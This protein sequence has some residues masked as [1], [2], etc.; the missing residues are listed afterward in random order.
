MIPGIA[1][2]ISMNIPVLLT[3]RCPKGRVLDSY[4]YEGG[5]AQLK[6]MGVIFTKNLNSQKARIRLMLV[7]GITKKIDE[8]EKYFK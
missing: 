8:I 5:G 1:Q 7:L 6:K 4:G 2:A 3:S